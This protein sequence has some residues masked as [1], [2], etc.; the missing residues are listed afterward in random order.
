MYCLASK[1]FHAKLIAETGRNQVPL[2]VI[3]PSRSEADQYLREVGFAQSSVKEWKDLNLRADATPTIIGVDNSGVIKGIWVGVLSPFDESELLKAIQSRSMPSST[4]SDNRAK[5][6]T[7]YS[8]QDVDELKAK[9]KISI[10]DTHER[11]YPGT[12]RDAITMPLLEVGYRAPVELDK[13]KLQVVDCSNLALSQCESSARHLSEAGFR[14][15][16]LNAGLYRQS[17]KATVVH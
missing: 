15:A 1:P 12:R 14:V 5:G 2:Y 16:T 10:V 13:N 4:L 6:L 9:Q 7:N 11:G 8:S 3:V 17:C